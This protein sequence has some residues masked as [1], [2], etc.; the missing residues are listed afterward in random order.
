MCIYIYMHIYSYLYIYCMYNSIHFTP[1]T[2]LVIASTTSSTHLVSSIDSFRVGDVLCVVVRFAGLAWHFDFAKR[3][4]RCQRMVHNC[5]TAILGTKILTQRNWTFERIGFWSKNCL[6][7]LGIG[8]SKRMV[9]KNAHVI[10]WT[11]FWRFIA[12]LG[13]CLTSKYLGHSCCKGAEA[14]NNHLN[15]YR[16]IY[17]YVYIYIPIC[18]YPTCS[19]FRVGAASTL[20]ATRF[21]SQPSPLALPNTTGAIE[22]SGSAASHGASWLLN[23]PI[24]MLRDDTEA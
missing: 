13:S 6:N 21:F 22:P 8:V 18:T 12:L 17:I 1:M 16:Y 3:S 15:V 10:I 20:N 4:N 7:H 9:A 11:Y 19:V 24:G 2:Y 14:I 5:Y 23:I